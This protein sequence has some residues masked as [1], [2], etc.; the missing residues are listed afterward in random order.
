MKIWTTPVE[1]A[2]RTPFEKDE[3]HTS[4]NPEYVQKFWRILTQV[5]RVFTEFRCR[6][7]GKA[8]PIHFFWGAF[9]LAVTRF[10]GVIDVSTQ[11]HQIQLALWRLKHI[12]MKCLVAVF[13]QAVVPLMDQ[14]SMPMRIRSQKDS[15]NF[16][17]NLPKPSIIKRWENTSYHMMWSVQ[18]R[19]L[20]MSYYLSY[21][22]PTKSCDIWK[23]GS[24]HI[25][26]PI[27]TCMNYR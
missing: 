19:L 6:F 3:K 25:G 22:A 15:A 17:H 13:G 16:L 11:G 8:S 21:R 26:T 12:P 27:I 9:D 2:D 18:L 24:N 23:L 10:S 7:N 4:Y 5:N 14:F 1:I 20:M